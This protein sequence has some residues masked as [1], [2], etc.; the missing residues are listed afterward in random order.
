MKTLHSLPLLLLLAAGQAA[1]AEG[2]ALYNSLE[3]KNCHDPVKDQTSTGGG[4]ALATIAALYSGDEEALV[5][6]LKGEAKPR[7]APESYMVMETQLAMILASRPEGNLRELA[8][9]ILSHGATPQ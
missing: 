9:Y 2:E 6:F 7:V 8:R 3:C 5:R 4:P 1:L